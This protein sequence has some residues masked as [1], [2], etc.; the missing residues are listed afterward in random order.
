MTGTT[1]TVCLELHLHFKVTFAITCTFTFTVTLTLTCTITFRITSQGGKPLVSGNRECALLQDP[2][3]H[4]DGSSAY[5]GHRLLALLAAP[6]RTAIALHPPPHKH[7]HVRQAVVGMTV[8]QL[9][10]ATQT[11][12]GMAEASKLAVQISKE[13]AG[14]ARLSWP[15]VQQQRRCARDAAR[16]GSFWAAFLHTLVARRWRTACESMRNAAVSRGAADAGG[17]HG[18]T[19]R[20]LEDEAEPWTSCRRELHRAGVTAEALERFKRDGARAVHQSVLQ[21]EEALKRVMARLQTHTLRVRCGFCDGMPG[22]M[23]T[24]IHMHCCEKSKTRSDMTPDP[25]GHRPQRPCAQG[26]TPLWWC[27]MLN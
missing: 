24:Y 5:L 15:S 6:M 1:N 18:M 14:C 26:R 21:A 3:V 2:S 19:H 4:Y 7:N 8:R 20:T 17:R 10:E 23:C 12:A 27:I 25:G 11:A 16:L 22:L 13:G 9:V